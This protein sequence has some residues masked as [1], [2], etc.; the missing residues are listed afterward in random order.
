MNINGIALHVPD[1]E[2]AEDY[3]SN[4]FDMTLVGREAPMPGS[5]L[6]EG[7]WATLPFDKGWADARAGGITLQMLSLVKGGFHLGLFKGQP[8]SGTVFAIILTLETDE[9]DGVGDRLTD[10]AIL[11]RRDDYLEMIDRFG[12]H[13]QLKTNSSWTPPGV[14]AGRWLDI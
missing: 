7:P 12:F 1:L 6:L 13:W 8:E 11:N 5:D 2:Q 10:E 3:Y 4:L 14:S 9:L